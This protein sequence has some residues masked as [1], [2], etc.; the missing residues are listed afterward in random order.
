VLADRATPEE[1]RL[2]ALR[3]EP[4]LHAH[5]ARL[6]VVIS[7]QTENVTVRVDDQPLASEL[8]GTVRSVPPGAHTVVAERA[9]V[10][11]SER[12]VQIS[13]GT[14]ALVDLNLALAPR[15]VADSAVSERDTLARRADSDAATDAR[16]KKR[17]TWIIVGASVVVVAAAGGLTYGLLR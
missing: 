5:I 15:Q 1:V 16:R 6:T 12:V 4:S 17:N 11:L 10:R 14:A 2:R 3:L 13:S 8:L 7:G 9:G